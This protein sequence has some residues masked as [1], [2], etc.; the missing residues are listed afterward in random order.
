MEVVPL[1]LFQQLQTLK[2]QHVKD[3]FLTVIH[4]LQ[5]ETA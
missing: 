2:L 4:A 1:D 5:I 3:V